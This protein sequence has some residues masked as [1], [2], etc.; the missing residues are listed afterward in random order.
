MPVSLSDAVRRLLSG[1]TLSWG[2]FGNYKAGTIYLPSSGA[3]R[4]LLYLLSCDRAKVA[5]AR[6]D[7]FGGLI[8]AWQNTSF[9]PATAAAP[10]SAATDNG[11][12]RIVRLESHGFGGLNLID[13]PNFV[14]ALNGEN[15]CLEGQNGSGKTSLASA[16]IWALTGYR[17][18]DQ[19][20][21]IVDDGR[22]IPVFNDSSVKIRDWPP[23]VAY[24]ANPARLGGTAEAWVR[25]T[26]R[27]ESGDTSEAFRR[28]VAP[29][30][31][32]PTFDVN[33]DAVLLSAPE[34]LE[35]GLLMPARLSRVG[36]G[37]RSQS[38]YEAVKLLTGLDQ[39][40]D[41]GEGSAN[42]K[43]KAK[44]F[45]KYGFDNGIQTIETKL[46]FSLRRAAEEALKATFDLNISAKRADKGFAKELRDIAQRA[47]AQAGTHLSILASD[48][49][50]GL[51]TNKPEDR[52]RIRNAVSA[53]RGILQ[54]GTKGITAFEAW[55]AL[56][57]A[58]T[59][60]AYQNLP[61]LLTD[62]R[63]RL[64]EAIAWDKRQSEDIKLRLKAL[65]SRFFVSTNHVH[66]DA[67]CPLCESKLSGDRRRALAAELAEL[68]KSSAA[69]ERKLA[70]A[71]RE[72][73]KSIRALLP[74]GLNVHFALLT[75]ME[76]RDAFEMAATERFAQEPPFTT[77]LTGMADFTK[78]TV[79][80]LADK[81][82][83]FEQGDQSGTPEGPPAARELLA[84][85]EEVE[86][87]VSLVAWWNC[88]RQPFVDSWTT[89]KG[90][91]TA[92]GKFPAE[93]LEGK[94]ALLEAA[95]E[96]AAPLDE[97]A[98]ALKDAADEAE[99]W[100]TIYTHQLVREAIVEALEPLT[101]LRTLVATETA[102]SISALSGRM[103]AILGR[104]HFKE[105]LSFEDAVLSKKAVQ[106]LGS[107]NHDIH[108]DAALVANTSWLRAILWAFVLAFREQTIEAIGANP[109]PLMVLDDPQV[110]FDPRNKRKWAEEIARLANADPAT[111]EAMQLLVI[112]HERQ[113]FQCL[114]NIEKLMG[115]Q[116]L[117][118][119]L[120]AA[121]QV[122]TVVNGAS[123][124]HDYQKVED[125]GDDKLGHH[126]IEEVRIYCEDLL[127]IM[128]RAEGPEVCDL[129]LGGLS[130]V[131]K[132]LRDASVAPFNRPSFGKL[133]DTIAGGGAKP[134][135][136]I[137]ESHH[138]FD[139]TIGVAQAADVRTF[140]E[141][142]LQTQI[143]TCFKVYAE[144]EAYSGE[145]RLFPWM[146]NVVPLPAGNTAELK[147]LSFVQTGIAAAASSDGRV[148]DGLVTIEELS[149]S[150]RITLHNHVAYQLAAGTLDPVATVG[151]VII[152]SNYAKVQARDL[153]VVAVGDQLLARRYNEPEIHPHIAVLTGQ[154][155]DPHALPKPIIA[156]LEKIAPRRIVGTLF[157]STRLSTPPKDENAEFVA[158]NDLTVVNKM[159]E[160]AKLFKVSGR[161]AEPIALD[162]QFIVTQP[163]ALTPISLRRVDGRPIVAI[164][165]NGARY[166]KR[167]RR[168]GAIVVL[169]SLNP[170]GTA[171][172][173]VLS[174]DGELGFP[175]L[176]GILEVVGVLFELPS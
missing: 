63:K 18:R 61:A 167:F 121:S 36:F 151:D 8:A 147:K 96:K 76:P 37:E 103:K 93:S 129:T 30:S 52:M 130:K 55:A 39:L 65:A 19:D 164:D 102:S 128:L 106:V 116:G 53:A 33:I 60:A 26:F 168:H 176:A 28:L 47:S 57:A 125:T 120:N 144:Y 175:R 41:I 75:R 16:I 24:P 90:V 43:H 29:E 67:E 87:I 50:N 115:Q 171:P 40:A 112:T 153:V 158:L 84:Y 58:H 123:L 27:N 6:E 95:L 22:R 82:P 14:L 88:N 13:G 1:D 80:T 51:D 117:V 21:V 138:K 137:N 162:G 140:W 3:R 134:M 15:W 73:E 10:A 48:V 45:L 12:W 113:F 23:L 174:I 146:D 66:D 136:I 91:A 86:R 143:H 74:Q 135:T 62:T 34:L 159:L 49:A 72:L 9:D 20:G 11:I 154:A 105:R 107:F 31:G 7:L 104:I 35:T 141:K 32:E 114:V 70:D 99:K 156:P 149:Q 89:L 110:T 132:K 83:S 161:S 44:R 38:I 98:R 4:L 100:L 126:Y 79:K 139:G 172:G 101:H 170:D 133:H 145:P 77:V 81:L 42:F 59:D 131:L 109:F 46:E 118:V 119:R 150:V 127:K 155:T 108:L 97:L 54:Q 56:K 2:K 160:D 92:D 78:T 64:Q 124:A 122:T 142:T 68:K 165:E 173:E 94:L 111:P 169:E 157:L 71:C 85:L 5:E 166:F 152:A 163:I 17:C 148:G 69:A 25:L